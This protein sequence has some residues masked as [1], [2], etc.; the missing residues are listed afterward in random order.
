MTTMETDESHLEL[1]FVL[2]RVYNFQETDF[3]SLSFEL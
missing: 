1:C 3:M 2:R